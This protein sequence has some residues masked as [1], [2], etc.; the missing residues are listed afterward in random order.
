MQTSDKGFALIKRFESCVLTAY[1]DPGTGGVP[2]TIGIGHTNNVKRGDVIT[3]PQAEQFLRDDVKVPELSIG[4]NVKV[5][6][7]QN[8]F[9]ALV[10]FIFNVGSKNFTSSTLIKK[11]NAGD[12]AGA[13]NEFPRWNKAAGRVLNGLTKRRAAERELF[14]S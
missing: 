4:T 11:L 6:L 14:L 13:A 12:Y 10:S 8:Q 1:P 3:Q 7:T 9:D 5:P 2:W